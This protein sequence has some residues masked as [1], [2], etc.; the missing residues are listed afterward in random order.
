VRGRASAARLLESL[1]KLKGVVRPDGTVTAAT[2]RRDDWRVCLAAADERSAPRTASPQGARCR[3]ATAGVA[4]HHG[5]G[6]GACDTQVLA[7]TVS[8]SIRSSH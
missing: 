6:S 4:A 3:H 1:A 2:H 7:L 5:H 8:G